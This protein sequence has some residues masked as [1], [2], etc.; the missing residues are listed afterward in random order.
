M[1][2]AGLEPASRRVAAR[3]VE[4]G[5]VAGEQPG[6]VVRGQ[7]GGE[8][9]VGDELA[10]DLGECS[11]GG[12]GVVRVDPPGSADRL[13]P[14]DVRRDEVLGD[15]LPFQGV[16][17]E[18]RRRATSLQHG[19]E[20][21][22]EVVRV[23][24]GH[25][26]ALTGLRGVGV[27]GV[28]GDEDARRAGAHLVVVHVVEL[29]GHPVADPVHREPRDLRGLERVR[30]QDMTGLIEDVVRREPGVG[31]DLAHVHV[32]ANQVAA[33]AGDEQDV[34]TAAGLD[35][36]LEPDVGEVGHRQDVHDTPRL[37]LA[38]ALR[39][40]TDGLAHGAVCT[41]ATDDVLRV[42]R[43]LGLLVAVAAADGGHNRL[44]V[45]LGRLE[46]DELVA[47]VGLQAAG[48]VPCV[49][50][51]EVSEPGLVDDDVRHFRNSVA[52]V[53]HAPEAFD[54]GGVG[55]IGPPEVGLV[56][57]VRLCRHSLGQTEGLERLDGPAVHTVRPADL[58]RAR[59]P[60]HHAGHDVRELGQL[61]REEQPR[62]SGADDE[63]VDLVRQIG[64]I[65]RPA[66]RRGP[67]PRVALSVTVQEVLHGTSLCSGTRPP[68]DS[69]VAAI[70]ANRMINAPLQQSDL[71]LDPS[72]AGPYFDH[73]SRRG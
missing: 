68:R 17:V 11:H 60:L 23:L 37:V 25:V 2:S 52:D 28:P 14:P 51:K 67:D 10:L 13:R 47:V 62:R 16:G 43:D 20:L 21:P 71:P 33:L 50:Q 38:R 72:T 30:G 63:D 29:V 41:V 64:L 26:H 73:R 58:Q 15:L 4:V 18:Q 32:Q 70:A 22:P 39:L 34:A 31:R 24:H 19:R 40:A 7:S 69:A 56:D 61:S 27:A 48:R 66:V 46:R 36:G 6:R 44:V 53:L 42:D 57:P 49:L 65:V 3:Q 8:L 55:R 9:A 54:A 12:L 59:C 35:R 5:V 45:R 1:T